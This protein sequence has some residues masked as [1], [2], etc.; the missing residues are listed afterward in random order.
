ML[1]IF[2]HSFCWLF[3]YSILGITRKIPEKKKSLIKEKDQYGWTPLHHAAYH[4]NRETMEALLECDVST[5]YIGDKDR[6]MTPLHIAISQGYI[7]DVLTS[8]CP[9]CCELVDERRW[10]ALH[11]AVLSLSI[12]DL[13]I[14]LKDPLIRN[15]IND[16][17]VDGNTPL[18]F[19]ATFRPRLLWSIEWEHEYIKFDLDVINNQN[20]SVYGMMIKSGSD[21][22]KVLNSSVNSEVSLIRHFKYIENRFIRSHMYIIVEGIYRT[23]STDQFSLMG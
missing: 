5:A 17:D 16:K 18:H 3:V 14:L 4:Q 1:Y 8:R 6:K 13:K 12:K 10:N 20:M 11:F 19:L 22:L 23:E 21:Q 15:L 7:P 9:D 2:V